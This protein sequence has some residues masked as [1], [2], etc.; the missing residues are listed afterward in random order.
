MP[1]AGI[2]TDAALFVKPVFCDLYALA[3]MIERSPMI[4]VLRTAHPPTESGT[5]LPP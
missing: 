4:Y 1:L 3:K 5:Y 2:V